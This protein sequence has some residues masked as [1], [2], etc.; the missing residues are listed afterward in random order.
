MR[1]PKAGEER[2]PSRALCKNTSGGAPLLCLWNCLFFF[3]FVFTAWK[4]LETAPPVVVCVY[5]WFFARVF[6]WVVRSGKQESHRSCEFFCRSLKMWRYSPLI[7]LETFELLRLIP[8]LFTAP[9][10]PVW[11]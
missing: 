3:L 7:S 11:L 2:T 8:L 6:L 9:I 4:P 1:A 5:F 10:T